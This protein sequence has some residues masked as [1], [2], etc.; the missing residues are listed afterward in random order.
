MTALHT[1]VRSWAMRGAFALAAAAILF[2]GRAWAADAPRSVVGDW[3][4]IVQWDDEQ[5]KSSVWTLMSNGSMRTA[6]NETGT[7][8][9]DG[10]KVEMWYRDANGLDLDFVG[11]LDGDRLVGV[12]TTPGH[13]ANFQFHANGAVGDAHGVWRGFVHWSNDP[14]DSL[15]Y[16]TW[17][18]GDGLMIV[19]DNFSGAYT[20]SGA[21]VSWR[22]TKGNH[23]SYIGAISGDTMTGTMTN[24]KGASGTFSMWRVE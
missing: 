20:Q 22:Y 7:W 19:S 2:G 13:V 1:A 17:T 15:I 18:F 21:Q 6:S 11:R 9:Q 23:S 10:R 16:A 8:R 3:P 14:P 12:A 4:G 24:D 5:P